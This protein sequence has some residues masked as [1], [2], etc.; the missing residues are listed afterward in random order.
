MH[1]IGIRT[2]RLRWPLQAIACLKL[3]AV[4]VST[5]MLFLDSIRPHVTH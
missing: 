2:T 4:H 1:M 3:K 5:V